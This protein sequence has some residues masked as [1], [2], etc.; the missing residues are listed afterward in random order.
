MVWRHE[1]HHL[2]FFKLSFQIVFFAKLAIW[3]SDY[4]FGKTYKFLSWIDFFNF[5]FQ[6]IFVVFDPTEHCPIF[7]FPPSSVRSSVR[8]SHPATARERCHIG[9]SCARLPCPCDWWQTLR[10]SEGSLGC[11]L[12][13]PLGIFHRLVSFAHTEKKMLYKGKPSPK[14]KTS[15]HEAGASLHN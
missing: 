2:Q 1:H 7:H 11:C 3:C 6:I 8:H 13:R 4:S 12:H 15:K 10:S 5:L 14:R 9:K